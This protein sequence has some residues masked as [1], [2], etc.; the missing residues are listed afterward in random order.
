M[1]DRVIAGQFLNALFPP[2]S[3]EAGMLSIWSMP[4]KATRFHTSTA[5]AADDA[6]ERSQRG[7]ESYFGLSLVNKAYKG[8]GRGKLGAMTAIGALW[9]DVDIADMVHKQ[10]N[11][12][13]DF[14]AATA[15]VNEA[16]LP[17]SVIVDSG[18]GMH[19][20]WLL[21]EAFAFAGDEER[22]RAVQLMHRW[23]STLK[24]CAAAHDWHLDA[25]HDLTSVLRVPGTV[26]HK[27]PSD[28]RPVRVMEPLRGFAKV[29]RYH[30][31][32]DFEQYF[33]AEEFEA[34]DKKKKA[35]VYEPVAP[36]HIKERHTAVPAIV[37]A[38]CDND[39]KFKKTWLR[40]RTDFTDQSPSSYDMAI[41]SFM[42]YA[43]CSDQ[44]IADAIIAHRIKHDG[45]ADKAANRRDYL[46]RTIGRA[47]NT[48]V[49]QQAMNNVLQQPT[50]SE[51]GTR[52]ADDRTKKQILEDLSKGLGIPIQQIIKHGKTNSTYAIKLTDDSEVT[53]GDISTLWSQDKFGQRLADE[54]GIVKR[55][56]KKHEWQR[57]VEQMLRTAD[58]IEITDATP[59]SIAEDWINQY[60]GDPRYSIRG[61]DDWAKG[62][63]DNQPFVK[64]NKLHIQLPDV[65]RWMKH[66]TP[67]LI[68]LRVMYT[69]LR[70]L[71]FKSKA[72]SGRVNGRK[73][74]R[75]YWVGAVDIL[76]AG[77][78][79]VANV[80]RRRLEVEL[81]KAILPACDGELDP[82]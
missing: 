15:L 6:F 34:G 63:D 32:H 20:Y 7:D 64:D 4:S 33:I 45:Q 16:G 1:E 51:G 62:L 14:K 3:F 12:P 53:I 71:G 70:K 37:N 49:A 73:I 41:A 81:G 21:T 31:P 42:V 44:D 13:P 59:E 61:D 79:Y 57:V 47:R 55:S 23:W 54:I 27:V 36:I 43:N 38:L 39:V 35:A 28:P 78:D 22:G 2:E 19:A 8:G 74:K 18:H 67:E 76:Q 77:I 17:P 48:C 5:S 69:G 75:H 9:A 65:M 68:D 26:N 58:L 52:Q 46:M 30:A 66:R 29:R 72:V 25:R 11:L 56:V 60:L 50:V 24:A 82:P 40:Q 80:E 10:F